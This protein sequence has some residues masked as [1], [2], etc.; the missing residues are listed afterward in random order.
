MKTLSIVI[1][2][3]CGT[4]TNNGLKKLENILLI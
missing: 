3:K 4:T 2:N 1:L